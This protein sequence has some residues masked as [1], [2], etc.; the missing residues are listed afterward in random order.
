MNLTSSI[1]ENLATV[2]TRI[3][4]CEI[5]YARQPGSVRLIAVSK[6]HPPGAI[7]AVHAAGQ[8]HFGENYL[9]EALD[10]MQQ[11]AALPLHWH[12]IGPIQSNKTRELARHF[13]W[14]HTVDREKVAQRLNEQRPA[15]RGQLN[16][17]LQVNISQ[18]NS[19]AGVSL[20]ELPDLAAVVA[21][22]P[23]LKLCGLMAIPAP[24]DDF[25]RQR[26]AFHSLVVARQHLQTLGY[27]HCRELSMGMSHDFA[28][29][30]AEQATMV[31]IGTDIFG[32]RA[33]A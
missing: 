28:A 23:R 4:D 16:I 30:I 26:A 21:K 14:V 3:T 12:Y 18:E 15:E 29:A 5:K 24:E 10:K 31:R 17:L 27:H 2:R 1:P 9:Q 33:K 20:Q 19:K 6:T 8:L 7:V 22:L 13:D 32:N 25:S 11:L